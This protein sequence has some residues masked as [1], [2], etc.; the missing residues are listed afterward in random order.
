MI[1]DGGPCS[2]GLESTV[3]DGM[4]DIPS[5]LRP[6]GISLDQIRS[7]IG[8]EKTILWTPASNDNNHADSDA[9]R[10]PGMKYTHYTP[11]CEV[12]LI[13]AKIRKSEQ[14]E[15][16]QQ[17]L[18]YIMCQ[19]NPVKKVGILRTGG[20]CEKENRRDENVIEIHLGE[21]NEN[22]ARNL[23]KGLRDLEQVGVEIILVEGVCDE[24]QG[25]AVMNRLFKASMKVI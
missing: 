12:V 24:G 14:R 7:C 17:Y 8:F 4:S 18:S 11:N 3:L 13:R 10:T 6:G 2:F 19:S 15:E 21:S 25:L 1:L 5:I 22:V 23:F 20:I 16:L 9:P